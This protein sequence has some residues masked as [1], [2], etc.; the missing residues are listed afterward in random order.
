MAYY[1]Y[2]LASR[3]DGAI[4]VGVTNDLIRRIYEHQIK[5]VPGFTAKYN[6]TRLVWFEIYDDPISAISREKELKKWKR[7]WKT[8]LVEKDNPNWNDLYESICK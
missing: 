8:Q 3:R 4:Y 5:A 7:A 2:I 1:I 6:I